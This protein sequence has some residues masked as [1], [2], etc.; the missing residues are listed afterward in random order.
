MTSKKMG[1]LVGEVAKSI[2]FSNFKI[3]GGK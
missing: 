1:V 2:P 3:Y